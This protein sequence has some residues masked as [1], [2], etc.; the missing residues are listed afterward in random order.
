MKIKCIR[1]ELLAACT[2]TSTATAT[3]SPKPILSN[4][5]VIS[6]ESSLTLMATDLEIGIRYEL[7]GVEILRP[8]SAI[9][10]VTHLVRVLREVTDDEVTI[11]S[12]PDGSTIRT[13]TG[14]FTLL[15]G[16]PTEFPDVQPVDTQAGYHEID[17]KI[18]KTM[19]RRVAFAADKKEGARWAVTG[20]LWETE[21]DVSRMVATDT[22]RL[23]KMESS[24]VF[25]SVE[26]G[27]KPLIP[28]KAILLLDKSIEEGP[29]KVSFTSKDA[30]FQT[31]NVQITT[32]LV[33]GKFPPYR[34]I[35]PKK[36]EV[37]LSLDTARFLTCVRQASIMVDDEIRRL[38]C[39]FEAGKLTVR[40]KGAKV[41]SSDVTMALPDY[42]GKTIEIS[43]DPGYL[44]DMLRAID[45]EP[46]LTVE[47]VDGKRPAIF[48]L[49]DYLYL[50]MPLA[51]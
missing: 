32:R 51:D 35:I 8:G 39:T 34:D 1:N 25:Y 10:P 16:D 29:V 3:R 24:A 23:A 47:M 27:L 4:I 12:T 17:A 43:F 7:P 33:E 21:G 42:T 37:K 45:G 5:K 19:I 44:I 49:G 18:L 14:T 20:I 28:Q 13:S 11:D 26:P 41:G 31:G 46:T 6:G 22:R 36:F 15:A 48:S 50:V 40:A 2:L 9:W 38:D 30:T